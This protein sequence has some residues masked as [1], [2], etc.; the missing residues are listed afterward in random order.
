MKL[1][2]TFLV[3]L[4]SCALFSQNYIPTQRQITAKPTNQ[5]LYNLEYE[6][7]HYVFSNGDSTILNSINLEDFISDRQQSVDVEIAAPSINQTIILYS[8]DKI[9]TKYLEKLKQ[10]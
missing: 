4:I 9:E 2:L 6:L 8:F 3:S 7:K 5:S 10:N 1:T